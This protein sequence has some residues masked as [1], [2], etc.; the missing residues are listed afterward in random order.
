[1]DENADPNNSPPKKKRAVETS[2]PQ[3]KIPQETKSVSFTPSKTP[4][5]PPLV[6]SAAK[7]HIPRPVAPQQQTLRQPQFSQTTFP[8]QQTPTQPQ[9]QHQTTHPTKSTQPALK[10]QPAQAIPEQPPQQ[11]QPKMD[12]ARTNLPQ[13]SHKIYKFFVNPL[14]YYKVLTQISQT[15]GASTFTMRHVD[16]LIKSCAESLSERAGKF[17]VDILTKNIKTSITGTFQFP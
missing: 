7:A 13:K 11:K 12:L 2:T 15:N 6:H 17:T 14:C 8:S 3:S 4:G 9:P 1:M 10:P 5:R 16:G